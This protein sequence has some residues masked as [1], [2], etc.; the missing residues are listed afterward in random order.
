M[1]REEY[2]EYCRDELVTSFENTLSGKPDDKQKH[3]TEGLLQAA[4]LLGVMDSDEV[5]Q[6]I[7]R[8]HFNVFG[9]TVQERKKRKKSLAELKEVSP[10]DY[11]SIP[12][13]E[14]R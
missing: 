1:N 9:E 11:F 2:I 7:E 14:R 10:D 5:T 13:I 12:A 6:L 8:E 3:R 4:R